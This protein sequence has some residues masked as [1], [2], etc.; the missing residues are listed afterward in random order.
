MST[1]AGAVLPAPMRSR[2]SMSGS[3]AIRVE[4]GPNV[5]ISSGKI[6]RPCS[7]TRERPMKNLILISCSDKK[8]DGG[9]SHP[10][11]ADPIPWLSDPG[12]RQRLF[13]NRSAVFDLIKENR[14][15]DS[16][17]KQ[18]NRGRDPRNANLVKGPEFGGSAEG[19]YLPACVRYDGR[20]FRTI[21]GQSSEEEIV[22]K[23]RGLRNG[24]DVLIVSGLYGL[25]APFDPIQEYTCHFADRISGC[26]TSLELLWR[27][28]LT[29]IIRDQAK[30][31]KCVLIDLLSEEAYEDAFDWHSIYESMKCLHRAYKLR[32]GPETLINSALFF[33]DLFLDPKGEESLICP[34][35]FISKDYFDDPEERILFESEFKTTRKEVAREGILE[36]LPQLKRRYGSA[37][38]SMSNKVRNQ[39]ANSEFSY[40]RN[41][42]L[43]EFDFTAASICLSKAIEIWLEIT[44]VAP[45]ATIPAVRQLLRNRANKV[46]SPHKATIGDVSHFFSRLGLGITG[47]LLRID[48]AKV[49]PSI[50]PEVLEELSGDLVKVALGF[51]NGWAHK[52][53]MP[54]EV[55]ERF[56]DAAVE[57]FNQWVPRW[58]KSN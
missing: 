55:Y 39:I 52:D 6:E 24:Y 47:G 3:E 56:R 53:P 45:L 18:G 14:L 27:D 21:R 5:M 50:N 44:I 12:L 46:I 57:F 33:S 15:A 1:V 22:A 54:R 32:A 58:K 40:M 10:V 7:G 17:K 9:R 42:D 29:D 43:R 8:R 34:D 25:V 31:E 49:F 19:A 37:W 36:F 20:F 13:E 11:D 48:S 16:E 23:W 4:N 38:D 30:G 26:D 2:V 35:R 41:R 28:L 51:R